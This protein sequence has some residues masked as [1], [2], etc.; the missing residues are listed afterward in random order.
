MQASN[1]VT[2]PGVASSRQQQATPPAAGNGSPS[3]PLLYHACRDGDTTVVKRL[4]AAGGIDVDAI[5]PDTRLAPLMLAARHGH[6]DVALVL[7]KGQQGANVNLQNS[8]GDSALSLA[9]AAGR[10]DVAMLLLE[11]K[12]DPGQAGHCGRTPLAEAAA[13]GQLRM[14]RLLLERGASADGGGEGGKPP[15][16]IA[17]RRG[18]SVLAALLLE[19]KASLDLADRHGWTA[20][21]HAAAMGHAALAGQLLGKGATPAPEPKAA[22][23]QEATENSVVEGS[24]DKQAAQGAM[25]AAAHTAAITAA[26]ITAAAVAAAATVTATAGAVTTATV[27]A[28][29]TATA[30]TST[31]ITTTAAVTAATAVI[32]TQPAYVAPVLPAWRTA[33]QSV[34]PQAQEALLQD[35]GAA[36]DMHAWL[37]HAAARGHLAAV[38]LLL[39]AG[40][41]PNGFDDVEG[42]T[43]PIP[44]YHGKQPHKER[45]LLRQ[46]TACPDDRNTWDPYAET[47]WADSLALTRAVRNGHAATA[48]ALL[49]AGARV[50][51]GWYCRELMLEAIRKGHAGIVKMLLD[52]RRQ[53]P[54]ASEVEQ[55]PQRAAPMAATENEPRDFGWQDMEQA[56][57]CAITAGNAAV[58]QA[59]LESDEGKWVASGEHKL[60]S[61]A[62][63]AQ[64]LAMIKALLDTRRQAPAVSELAQEPHNAMQASAAAK[65]PRDLYNQDMEQA[66]NCAITA[67]NAAVLQALLE[68]DEG[69]WVASGEHKLLSVA[70]EKQNLAMVKALL[71]AG[72]SLTNCLY[73]DKNALKIA[74]AKGNKDI[75]DAL[76]DTVG[77]VNERIISS[78]D[79]P[80]NVAINE[81]NIEMVRLLLARGYRGA[82]GIAHAFHNACCCGNLAVVQALLDAGAYFYLGENKWEAL[83]YAASGGHAELVAFLLKLKADQPGY[84]S[85]NR[86]EMMQAALFEAVSGRKT[87]PE[88]PEVVRLL[89]QAGADVNARDSSSFTVLMRAA[90]NDD[91]DVVRILLEAG[92]DPRAWTR[93]GG[94]ALQLARGNRNWTIEKL[95]QDWKPKPST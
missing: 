9:A 8:R 22:S 46:F 54:A 91:T 93:Y 5:D 70:A 14:A 73:N 59:L 32:A 92:A 81:K 74:I 76:L 4:L 58:L 47:A 86:R 42:K 3:Q 83:N 7:M 13:G 87:N 1:A 65:E 71:A 36:A 48:Q 41:N 77:E 6:D 50:D 66:L 85:G 18:D 79:G 27:T 56:L 15:L 21:H 62:A 29:T 88:K 75:V 61:A 24:G 63:H 53:A 44:G 30:Q 78:D 57:N 89:L 25:P 28:S 19:N 52:A 2:P 23:Q 20:F 82:H 26:T 69:K 16:T 55:A 38:R 35:A 11:R 45:H 90:G 68:S 51:R 95:L 17:A 84:A 39:D 10:E 37:R 40:A 33:L 80:L 64:N 31:T 43:G 34:D 49:A 60:L 12:A 94:D 67:G 72:A